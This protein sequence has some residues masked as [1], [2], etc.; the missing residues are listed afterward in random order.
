VGL[1]SKGPGVVFSLQLSVLVGQVGLS[2][3][4]FVLFGIR[5]LLIS[6]NVGLGSG[7]DGVG[8]LGSLVGKLKLQFLVQ[9]LSG[10]EVLLERGKSV[11]VVLSQVDQSGLGSLQTVVVQLSRSRSQLGEVVDQWLDEDVLLTLFEFL[12]QVLGEVLEGLGV[13]LQEVGGRGAF[14]LSGG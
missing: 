5:V 10:L 8:E 3:G 9:V 4:Q 1:D 2:I 11:D 14:A 12:F 13:G 6:F 7:N